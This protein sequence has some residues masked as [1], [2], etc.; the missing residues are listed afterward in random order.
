MA[1][2]FQAPF[3]TLYEV[4][5]TGDLSEYT[6]FLPPTFILFCRGLAAELVA[7]VCVEI[8]GDLLGPVRPILLGTNEEVQLEGLVAAIRRILVLHVPEEVR[9]ATSLQDTSRHF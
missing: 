2:D 9:T 5:R 8:V 7:R 4:D 3:S 1:R 6:L